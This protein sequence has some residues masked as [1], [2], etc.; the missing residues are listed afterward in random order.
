[1]IARR[2]STLAAH[3]LALLA[4]AHRRRYVVRGGL[5]E[6]TTA[7][8]LGDLIEALGARGRD[9]HDAVTLAVEAL[10]SVMV[11]IRGLAT[12]MVR[13]GGSRR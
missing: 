7:E 11:A 13:A 2:T 8:T 4:D 10:W 5:V 1:M 3:A 9:Y 12:A 6:R